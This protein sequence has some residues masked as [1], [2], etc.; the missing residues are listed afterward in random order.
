MNSFYHGINSG[1][2]N[3][4][5]VRHPS[6]A[7]CVA[8]SR[9]QSP[10]HS[11]MLRI[12]FASMRSAMV[13]PSLLLFWSICLVYVHFAK[14]YLQS[15]LLAPAAL[16]VFLSAGGFGFVRWFWRDPRRNTKLDFVFDMGD[17]QTSWSHPLLHYMFAYRNSLLSLAAMLS[18]LFLLTLKIKRKQRIWM[19]I[20][21]LV[22]SL[23]SAQYQVFLGGAVFVILHILINA[24]FEGA[25]GFLIALAI[26]AAP[27]IQHFVPRE[28]AAPL[29]KRIRLWDHLIAKGIFFA[30]IYVWVTSLGAFAVVSLVVCWF[31]VGRQL[32]KT[33][34]PAIWVFVIANVVAFEPDPKHAIH[35][36]YP[37]WMSVASVVFIAAIAGIAGAPTGEE[38]K[39]IATAW[40]TVLFGVSI[41]AALLG[42][43]RL[44]GQVIEAWD[45]DA[46]AAGKWIAENTPI[47]AVFFGPD[48]DYNPV[49]AVAGRRTIFH[50][51]R[52]HSMLGLRPLPA[53]KGE[54]LKL[55]TN[56]DDNTLLPKV[57]YYVFNDRA[58]NL[59]AMRNTSR[60]WSKV[61]QYGRYA[62]YQRPST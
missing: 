45:P 56:L 5:K 11:A 4:F 57:R 10:F 59:I 14:F 3:I 16:V 53:E 54:L 42:F 47:K 26:V 8:R 33:Y 51:D 38:G 13:A 52:V 61:C 50:N 60:N 2:I 41:A 46:E 36:L 48:E 34:L 35:L 43:V 20:G 9:W 18:V 21:G 19:L 12:G 22:G 39:G 49:S 23:L 7:H 58:Q 6:C 15:D 32:L 27:Q 44:R 25:K 40:A 28:T 62:V 37:C 29:V 30:P 24:R 31:F 17:Q 1:F 55:T